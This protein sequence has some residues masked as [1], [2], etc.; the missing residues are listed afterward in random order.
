MANCPQ[1]NDD[2]Y[3]L[4][5][6]LFGEDGA[7]SAWKL[8]GETFPEPGKALEQLYPGTVHVDDSF[9]TMDFGDIAGKY[10]PDY[11]KMIDDHI[12]NHPDIPVNNA[13][14]FNGFQDRVLTKFDK[15][16]H[17][18]P[19]NTVIVTHSSIL[20]LLNLWEK[21]GRPDSYRVNAKEY[22][23]SQTHT[24]DVEKFKSDNGHIYVVRH[25]ET[26]DNTKGNLRGPLTDLTDKGIK[27]AISAG[28]ELSTIPISELY[29]SPLNRALH[30]SDL[31]LQKQPFDIP[32]S[33]YENQIRERQDYEKS[34]EY[35]NSFLAPNE[36]NATLKSV[37]IFQ[38]PKAQQE[39]N[40]LQKGNITIDQFLQNAQFPKEQ[41][42]LIKDI[43]NNDKPKSLNDL[44]TSLAAK[45]SYTVEINIAKEQVRDSSSTG[46]GGFEVNGSR[47]RSYYAEDGVTQE[48]FKDG[49]KIPKVAYQKAYE[50]TGLDKPKPTQHY[51][52]LTVPGGT[53]YTENEIATPGIVPS[54][55]GH[56]QFSTENGIGWFR[57]DD[58]YPVVKG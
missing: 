53:N 3:K 29:T 27:Q 56:A 40:K 31:I 8:A 34:Y 26:D 43:Y 12:L 30:T 33:H 38:T 20:K 11:E 24:G 55:K 10:E 35:Q 58:K 22:T 18:A 14:S 51:S 23:E 44:A 6:K 21:E 28:K 4:L 13:E 42:E 50:E 32:D 49:N 57:S 45:Y 2:R 9:V 7:Y 1:K 16:L 46:S 41:K 52:N 48:Y 37:E 54:I 39:W 19:D 15:L 47:Y 5:E 36:V 17:S 25:G